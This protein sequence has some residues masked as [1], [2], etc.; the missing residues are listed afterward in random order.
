[1]ADMHSDSARTDVAAI[2]NMVAALN[3]S[4][5]GSA[6]APSEVAATAT[7]A[8]AATVPAGASAA[9]TPSASTAPA[10]APNA[11]QYMPED[12]QAVRARIV[13][14]L[15]D[16]LKV[17]PSVV[18]TVVTLIDEGNTIPF[19]ARYRKEATGGMDDVALRALAERLSYLRNLENRKQI[20]L[21]LIE[22]QG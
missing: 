13:K 17:R 5:A 9:P 6:A 3:P 15:A 10:A 7:T 16:E 14:L 4:N 22:A 1:M 19:I 2:M 20:V 8:T 12:E 11:I 21:T 18:D